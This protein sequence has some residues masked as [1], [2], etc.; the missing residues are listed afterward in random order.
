MCGPRASGWGTSRGCSIRKSKRSMSSTPWARSRTSRSRRRPRRRP[1]RRQTS[2][3]TLGGA[4]TDDAPLQTV[5]WVNNRGGSGTAS[6]TNFWTIRDVPLQPGDNVITVSTIDASGNRTLG[7]DHGHRDHA[8]LLARGRRD[9]QLLRP[10]RAD[11]E[12]D[13]DARAGDGHVPAPGRPADRPEPDAGADLAHDAARGPD[14]GPREPGRRV[15][16]RH[17]HDGRA[18]RGRAHDVLGRELLRFAR[19]HRGGRTAD[20]LAVRRGIGR[21]S[22]TRTCCSRT[23]VR[24]RRT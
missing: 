22:S 12:P 15:R 19:R 17:V 5:T 1:R 24:P 4:V 11:R 2:F 18:P 7:R 10:R 20:A 3:I 23:R 9:R 6:G 21:A 14:P 8:D 16:R 13:H